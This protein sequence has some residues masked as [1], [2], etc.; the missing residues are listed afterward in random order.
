[1]AS[2]GDIRVLIVLDLLLSAVFGTVVVW[3]LSLLG[4]LTFSLRTAALA[5]LL[6]AVVTYLAVLR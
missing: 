4:V 1:M 6:I 5:T 2:D 3:G